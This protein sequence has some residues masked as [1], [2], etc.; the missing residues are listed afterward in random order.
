MSV[1]VVFEEIEKKMMVCVVVDILN[2][3]VQ[4]NGWFSCPAFGSSLARQRKTLMEEFWIK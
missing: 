2:P 3:H 1:C 4:K